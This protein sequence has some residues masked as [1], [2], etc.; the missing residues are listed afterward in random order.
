MHAT[1]H[2]Y[3]YGLDNM[4]IIRLQNT[5]FELDLMLIVGQVSGV[6]A[7]DISKEW[8]YKDKSLK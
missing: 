2:E 6:Y 5:Q 1:I 8:P 7:R 4:R 3:S